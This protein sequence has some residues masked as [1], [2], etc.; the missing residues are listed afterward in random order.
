MICTAVP[1]IT[2]CAAFFGRAP[3]QDYGSLAAALM[4][5]Q[6]CLNPFFSLYFVKPFRSRLFHLFRSTVDATSTIEVHPTATKI[7]MRRTTVPLTGGR[8]KRWGKRSV[9]Q[10]PLFLC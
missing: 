9:G 7:A 6:P 5:W 1:L 3:L 10:S 2:F 8:N 4:N